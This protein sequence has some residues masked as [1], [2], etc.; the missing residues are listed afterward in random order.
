MTTAMT[1]RAIRTP[2]AVAASSLVTV[3]S[4]IVKASSSPHLPP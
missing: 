1:I 2:E 4:P 3:V